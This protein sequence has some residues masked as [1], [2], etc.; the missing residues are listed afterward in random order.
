MWPWLLS[1]VGA[2]KRSSAVKEESQV[3][4]PPEFAHEPTPDWVLVMHLSI[5]PYGGSFSVVVSLFADGPRGTGAVV[6]R[7]NRRDRSPPREEFELRRDVVDLLLFVLSDD[8]ASRLDS[9]EGMCCDG[10]PCKLTVYRRQPF[11]AGRA[12]CNLGDWLGQGPGGEGVPLVATL[13]LL[14]LQVYGI[15]WEPWSP[16]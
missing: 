13:G 10:F 9:V 6:A 3:E 5:R 1:M 8:F 12:D 2:V 14:L 7:S 16:S 15:A 11:L 4:A